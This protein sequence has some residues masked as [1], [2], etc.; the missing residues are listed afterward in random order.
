[1]EQWNSG[2]LGPL[3]FHLFEKAGKDATIAAA[4]LRPG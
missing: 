1:M 3:V 4:L 2:I